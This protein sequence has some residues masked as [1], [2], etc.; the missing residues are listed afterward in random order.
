MANLNKVQLI[1]RLGQDPECRDTATGS[2]ANFSIATNEYWT[3]K[4]GVKQE[5]T[6]WHNLVLWNKQAELA[7]DYLRAGSQI[8]VEGKLQTSDWVNPEGEKRYKTEVVVRVMQFL[9]SKTDDA[10]FPAQRT[11][12]KP[13]PVVED[14]VKDDIPF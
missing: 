8:Y 13:A 1:G 2:V 14:V 11:E 12:P 4:A 10:G 9:D 5:S 3:D 7:R 6:E